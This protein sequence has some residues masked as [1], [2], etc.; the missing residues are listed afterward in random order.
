MAGCATPV[1]N[2]LPCSPAGFVATDD[3]LL[4]KQKQHETTMQEL[5]EVE[6]VQNYFLYNVHIVLMVASHCLL[7]LPRFGIL[8]ND[9]LL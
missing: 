7:V 5:I 3:I 6:L 2:P 9:N 8:N 1:Q 4:D